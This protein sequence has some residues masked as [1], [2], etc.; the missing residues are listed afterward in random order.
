M[1]LLID[2]EQYKNKSSFFEAAMESGF[3]VWGN[4]EQSSN[5][6]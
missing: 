6:R 3:V 1:L 2:F 4:Q 5:I